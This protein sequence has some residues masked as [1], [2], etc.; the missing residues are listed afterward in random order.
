MEKFKIISSFNI[1]ALK[2]PRYLGYPRIMSPLGAES[3][4]ACVKEE[5]E[6]TIHA[7]PKRSEPEM[8]PI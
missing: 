7:L 5:G 3:P 4:Y 2:L 8:I 1:H 6:N